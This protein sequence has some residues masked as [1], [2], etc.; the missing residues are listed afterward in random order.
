MTNDEILMMKENALLSSVGRYL[1]S[2]RLNFVVNFIGAP[3]RKLEDGNST[4]F[5]TKFKTL[6]RYLGRRGERA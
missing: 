2:A 5:A 3:H 4:K 6:N 1:F